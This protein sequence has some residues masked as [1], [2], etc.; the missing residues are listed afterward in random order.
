MKLISVADQGFDITIR[1]TLFLG[2]LKYIADKNPVKTSPEIPK[3]GL[4]KANSSGL[5]FEVEFRLFK[6]I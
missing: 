5:T 4:T 2:A 1:D 6:V 3:E